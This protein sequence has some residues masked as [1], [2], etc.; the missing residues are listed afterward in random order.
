MFGKVKKDD[1]IIFCDGYP[2]SVSENVKKYVTKLELKLN[3]TEYEL[4]KARQELKAIKPV[5]ETGKLKPAVSKY[6]GDCKH[7]VKS[8]W[9]SDIL[10]CNK[11]C[12]CGDFKPIDL[13]E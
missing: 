7:C 9:N 2:M 8:T 13:E 5:I 6:C 3:N 12:I 1:Y 10:G 11:D 4:S